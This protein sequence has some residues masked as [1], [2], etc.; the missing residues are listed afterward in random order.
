[1]IRHG[2]R[3]ARLALESEWIHGSKFLVAQH[4]RHSRRFDTGLDGVYVAAI[5]RAEGVDLGCNALPDPFRIGR[6]LDVGP[7][8]I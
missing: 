7:R 8:T 5:L 3:S 1:M 2:A 4:C 6:V